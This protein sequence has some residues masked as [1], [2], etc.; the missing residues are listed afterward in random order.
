MG[1]TEFADSDSVC[2]IFCTQINGL[3]ISGNRKADGDK[4]SHRIPIVF[5]WILSERISGFSFIRSLA[6][7]SLDKV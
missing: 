6:S 1:G 4:I 2:L 7:L 3:L 5:S